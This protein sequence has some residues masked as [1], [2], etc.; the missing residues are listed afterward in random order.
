[1]TKD[2]TK[3]LAYFVCSFCLIHTKE[4]EKIKINI[5]IR[6]RTKKKFIRKKGNL[7]D[8]HES[9]N[10]WE[11]QKVKSVQIKSVFFMILV[12][13][14]HRKNFINFIQKNFMEKSVVK[15]YKYPSAVRG[16]AWKVSKYGVFSGPYFPVFGLNTEIY[17]VNLLDQSEHR[18][19]R[20]RKNSVFGHFLRSECIIITVLIGR[21]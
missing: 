19:V 18:K 16:T 10:E 20:T 7:F 4:A 14:F 3:K 9:S 17:S 11:F 8:L 2:C 12:K 13:L 6:M 1:M 15:L 5:L 21:Q